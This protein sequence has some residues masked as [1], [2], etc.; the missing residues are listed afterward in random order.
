MAHPASCWWWWT[1][2]RS[3]ISRATSSSRII[4]APLRWTRGNKSSRPRRKWGCSKQTSLESRRLVGTLWNWYMFRSLVNELKLRWRKNLGQTS[5]AKRS[6]AL[7]TICVPSSDHAM[8]SGSHTRSNVYT[9]RT[10]PGTSSTVT[11]HRRRL[12]AR[13]AEFNSSAASF[14]PCSGSFGRSI[15]FV[16]AAIACFC[17]WAAAAPAADVIVD[18]CFSPLGWKGLRFGTTTD[19]RTRERQRDRLVGGASCSVCFP[20]LEFLHGLGGS[21]SG[22]TT[23]SPLPYPRTQ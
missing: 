14:I 18:I 15:G 12:M 3:K 13:A 22:V 20:R 21:P 5:A 1:R 19:T 6:A 16:N 10:K 11:R 8:I 23:L 4:W 2:L 17:C 9:V 7:I